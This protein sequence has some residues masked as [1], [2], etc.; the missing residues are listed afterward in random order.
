MRK[1]VQ[2]VSEYKI[3]DNP[4]WGFGSIGTKNNDPSQNPHFIYL[5]SLGDGQIAEKLH[6][7]EKECQI[8]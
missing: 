6:V 1:S 2:D 3:P 8:L 4:L 5:S 7:K